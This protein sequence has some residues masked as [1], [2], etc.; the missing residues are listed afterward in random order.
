MKAKEEKK[1]SVI[2]DDEYVYYENEYEQVR[3][4]IGMYIS[5]RGSKAAL[6]LF[7]E[8]FNNA[9]DECVNENSPADHIDI[10]PTLPTHFCRKRRRTAL[11]LSES[12]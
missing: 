9:L 8:I 7:K 4:F 3:K 12:A 1:S 2:K 5:Y 11:A 6:H 10:L